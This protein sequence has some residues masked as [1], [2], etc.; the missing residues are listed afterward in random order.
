MLL[1]LFRDDSV[2]IAYYHLIL[3]KQ[4]IHPF[5]CLCVCLSVQG[6]RSHF[7]SI[8]LKIQIQSLETPGRV[9]HVFGPSLPFLISAI[10]N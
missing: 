10:A 5:V 2:D 1:I 3:E 4:T 9:S 7:A 6:S 8:D